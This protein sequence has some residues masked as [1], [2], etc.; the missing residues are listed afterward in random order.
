MLCVLPQRLDGV[1]CFLWPQVKPK[2]AVQRRHLQCLQLPEE[3]QA[4]KAS[5]GV[6]DGIH[7]LHSSP[8]LHRCVH[9]AN[10]G[11]IKMWSNYCYCVFSWSL[12]IT[13]CIFYGPGNCNGRRKEFLGSVSSHLNRTV[14]S[15]LCSRA[16]LFFYVFF[17][18]Y[19][20]LLYKLIHHF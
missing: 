2:G 3:H 16:V 7:Q 1:P 6:L 10:V 17:F 15:H 18:F 13:K 11:G 5:A 12:L 20:G 4:V 19:K 14:W 9:V 8:H